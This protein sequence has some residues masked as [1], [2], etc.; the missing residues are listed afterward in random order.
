[1]AVDPR[2]RH[3]GGEAVEQFEWGDDQR[4]TAVGAR[5]G[6]IVAEAFEPELM[7]LLQSER[8]AGAITQQ[9]LAPGAVGSLDAHRGV[10]RETAAMRPLRHRL[11]V[12]GCQ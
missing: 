6:G 12:V 5:C 10:D 11:G 8:W 2:W 1:V 9:A 7:Q 3:E 4:A